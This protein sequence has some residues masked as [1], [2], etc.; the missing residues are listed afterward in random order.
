MFHGR[1][2]QPSWIGAVLE[3]RVNHDR[4]QGIQWLRGSLLIFP[5]ECCKRPGCR[6]RSFQP[7]LYSGTDM[8]SLCGSASGKQG[9]PL[10]RLGQTTMEIT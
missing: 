3:L 5:A 7:M 2:G 8:L 9:F 10:A 6:P 1:N 4:I